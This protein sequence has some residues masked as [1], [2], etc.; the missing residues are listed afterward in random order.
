MKLSEFIGLL[1]VSK[2]VDSKSFK[3]LE[4]RSEQKRQFRVSQCKIDVW[5]FSILNDREL[6]LLE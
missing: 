5:N 2:A 3:S 4:N 6:K 1:N